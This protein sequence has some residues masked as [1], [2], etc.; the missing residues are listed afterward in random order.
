MKS[1]RQLVVTFLFVLSVPLSVSAE[2]SKAVPAAPAKAAAQSTESAAPSEEGK[3]NS[4]AATGENDEEM[5][6]ITEEVVK[7]EGIQSFTVEHRIKE[8]VLPKQ[9]IDA[10]PLTL[11]QTLKTDILAQLKERGKPLSIS[12]D[13]GVVFSE[14]L[15]KNLGGEIPSMSVKTNVDAESKGKSEFTLPALKRDLPAQKDQG[16]GSFDWKGLQ[17]TL[18]FTDKF[19]N[20]AITVNADGF[21]VMANDSLVEL[22]KTSFI[23]ELDTDLLPLSFDFTMP[24]FKVSDKKDQFQMDVQGVVANA[25]TKKL[26]GGLDLSEGSFKISQVSFNQANSKG[27]LHDFELKGE[28]ELQGNTVRYTLNTKM[29]KLTL[30]EEAIGEKL[31]LSY[32]GNLEFRRLDAVALAE[33]QKTARDLQ[34]QQ[35]SGVI[36]QEMLGIAMLGKAMEITPKLLAKSPEFALTEFAIKT[37]QGS[38][39]G[40]ATIGIDGKKAT[41]LDDFSKLMTAVQG[42]ADFSMTKTLLEK[43]TMGMLHEQF[44]GEQPESAKNSADLQKKVKTASDEHIKE[45][46]AK[47]YLVEAGDSYK[48]VAVF[49]EG[50]LTINGQPIELPKFS[51]PTPPAEETPAPKE[52]DDKK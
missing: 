32:V 44:A 22:G 49:K 4:A 45:L 5:G 48:L 46:L 10:N 12:T 50:Q 8:T 35:H 16:K 21:V 38:L 24:S 11:L 52:E 3:E 26:T 18:A 9:T 42:Q 13:V 14:E 6:E 25:K 40:K 19:D 7:P 29:G 41:S 2:T 28:G 31:D 39:Q 1:A 47:K 34:K 37:A 51:E 43:V 23:G 36:S 15:A 27:E 17:G 30:P 20:L 33:I